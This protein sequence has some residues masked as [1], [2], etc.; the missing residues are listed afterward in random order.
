[1]QCTIVLLFKGGESPFCASGCVCNGNAVQFA[2]SEELKPCHISLLNKLFLNGLTLYQSMTPLGFMSLHKSLLKPIYIFM[3]S[4]KR[5][6]G[7]ACLCGTWLGA[8][9][10]GVT[11]ASSLNT[12][13]SS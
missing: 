1:M 9:L 10:Q 5:V 2:F 6:K 11:S 3:G 8:L 4:L 12:V 13:S 7:V